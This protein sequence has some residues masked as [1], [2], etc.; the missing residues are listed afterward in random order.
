M[1][2]AGWI[3][4]AACGGGDGGAGDGDAGAGDA[5]PHDAGANSDAGAPEDSGPAC[6]A[7]WDP[8]WIGG[9]CDQDTDCEYEGGLCLREDEGFPCG[10]CSEGCA[11]YCPDLDSAPVTFC[12]GSGD[13][14]LP[15]GE[16]LCLSR[17]D[18]DRF[19]GDGCRDGYACAVLPRFGDP[20]TTEGTCV[21]ADLAPEPTDCLAALDALGLDW[22]PTDVAVDHPDGRP[23]LT[24]E[25]ADPVY[26][27]G[28]IHGVSFRY[29]V[30]GD[31]GPVLVACELARA[32]EKMAALLADRGVV[33]FQHLG[34][35]NCR[36]IAGS[37]S[38]SMHGYALAIDL[39]GF[40]LDDG[41]ELTVLDDWEDGV[42]DPVTFGGQWL[43]DVATSMFD[44]G[45]Y[46]IIL[47]PEYNAA[48]DNHFHCDLTPDAHFMGF[49]APNSSVPID[50]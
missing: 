17:C 20:G 45:I 4:L 48:H 44:E 15:G 13:V 34:T 14:G 38:I 10:T 11:E 2:W 46:N 39:Q 31:E 16:G 26:L 33:D 27:H 8:S 30:G 21:P 24:C 3:L 43:K 49:E 5:G 6:D 18:P 37:D 40:L 9:P 36:V 12:A 42:A 7:R 50:P 1:T 41:T 22:E 47:T 19:G 25:I 35:Y 32:I 28:P 23:D 29:L